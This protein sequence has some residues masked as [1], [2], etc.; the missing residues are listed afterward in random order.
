[1]NADELK[2]VFREV[3]EARFRGVSFDSVQIRESVDHHNDA[4]LYVTVTFRSEAPLDVPT[5]VGFV[6]HVRP[7]L[8]ALG[9]ERFP[10]M[11][12]IPSRD[13]PEGRPPNA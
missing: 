9:E 3:L 2:S 10:I 13:N 12:F 1:M 11:S 8:R 7:R 6:R 5:R 4:V